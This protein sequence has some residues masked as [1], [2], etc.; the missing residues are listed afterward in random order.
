MPRSSSRASAWWDP[1]QVPG[2]CRGPQTTQRPQACVV[3]EFCR[4]EVL[5][6]LVIGI[7][8]PVSLVGA[9]N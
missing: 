3:S 6:H 9:D 8:S 5:T 1:S 7:G 2:T 4:E